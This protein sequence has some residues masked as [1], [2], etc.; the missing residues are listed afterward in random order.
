M[1]TTRRRL[2]FA[3]LPAIL[4][5]G[6]VVAPPAPAA[7]PPEYD[8]L[9]ERKQEFVD[10][11]VAAEYPHDVANDGRGVGGYA[12]MV[13]FA[14]G[15]VADGRAYADHHLD[16]SQDMFWGLNVME[17]YLGYGDQYTP[18]LR[19]KAKSKILG[20]EI[21]NA[22]G[23]GF[24]G[25]TPNHRLMYAAVGLTAGEQWPGEYPANRHTVARNYLLTTL[26]AM[27]TQGHW[28]YDATTYFIHYIGP[29]LFLATHAQDV[30]IKTMSRMTLEWMFAGIVGEYL[31]GALVGTSG[32]TYNPMQGPGF[33]TQDSIQLLWLLFGGSRLPTQWDGSAYL[34]WT[35]MPIALSD[36]ALP[37]I[38]GRIALDRDAPY[39]HRERMGGMPNNAH[40]TSYVA[41][42]YAVYSQR[43]N[44]VQMPSD[45]GPRWGVKWA[46]AT[47][48]DEP[49]AFFLKHHHPSNLDPTLRTYWQGLDQTEEV[50][51]KDG[52][53]VVVHNI[54]DGQD[55]IDGPVP[56]S[57]DATLERGGWVFLH[58]GAMVLGVK[59]IKGYTWTPDTGTWF[60]DDYVRVLRSNGAKNGVIVETAPAADYAGSAAQ[61]LDA[62]A[63]D[64]SAN[65]H[66]DASGINDAQPRLSYTNL[67]GHT[68][69]I[70]YGTSRTVDGV[71]VD[72]SDWPLLDD[73]W[74]HQDYGSTDLTLTH[75]GQTRTYDFAQWTTS[76]VPFADDFEDGDAA[77]W[78]TS[79][80]AWSVPTDG[81][82]V[83]RQS[84]L[85]RSYAVGGMSTWADYTYQATVEPLSFGAPS[86]NPTVGLLARYTNVDNRYGFLYSGGTLAI[87][88]NVGGVP[89]T[90]ASKPYPLTP[91]TA[92]TFRAAVD[93]A[94]LTFTVNGVPQLMA[95]DASL[96]A[97]RIA[98]ATN[99][100]TAQ[101]DDVTVTFP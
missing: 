68:L 66:I 93:D 28:E 88:K 101:F 17:A 29:L 70:T 64:I 52:T 81:T 50:L 40:K 47:N 32:R 14:T 73:P 87:N 9:E 6:A 100:A 51:Q 83:Y 58:T 85:A 67:A 38:F 99:N 79:G 42:D 49:G 36:F 21:L 84:S 92:Y 27:V 22:A 8:T 63:D 89:T 78:T 98:F 16:L 75:D 11:A 13:Q 82:D 54:T 44:R 61:Q 25:S 48:A 86:P 37:D 19:A 74:V 76:G 60:Y 23:T 62:F 30:Q 20:F 80:G 72:Y 43:D 33:N 65:A 1:R 10:R 46:T 95:T 18:E 5:L 96:T 41:P 3:V 15:D 69:E 26:P 39:T 77:G 91:G 71:A 45:S 2:G 7:D 12:A 4:V 31:K 90:L 97:G 56:R 57:V 35:F 53:L 34:P 94:S 59:P 24:L 55:W